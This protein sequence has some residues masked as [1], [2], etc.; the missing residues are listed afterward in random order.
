VDPARCRV[1]DV[2][3][4][5]DAIAAGR[6]VC[7]LYESGAT[8]AECLERLRALAAR[9]ERDLLPSRAPGPGD[10]VGG[11]APAPRDRVTS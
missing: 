4:P 8:T 5:G 2:P 10:L 6:P 11:A 1:A 3:F 9:V 7:T